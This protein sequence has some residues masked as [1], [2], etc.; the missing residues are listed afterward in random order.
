MAGNKKGNTVEIVTDIVKPVIE[1]MGLTLWDVRFEKEGAAFLIAYDESAKT[2]NLKSLEKGED[3]ET[4]TNLSVWLFD[5]THRKKDAETIGEDF[6]DIIR[7]KLGIAKERAATNAAEVAL[8]T[9]VK[10]DGALSMDQFTQRF[11]AVYPQ[12]KDDYKENVAANGSF[13]P[14]EFYRYRG[15]Q[16]LRE[17]AASGN[18]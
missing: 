16:K 14:I 1:E 12:Y 3:G 2:F 10:K 13:M 8:P 6:S 9:R 7:A 11:L 4:A 5:E 17:V 18:K 15:A